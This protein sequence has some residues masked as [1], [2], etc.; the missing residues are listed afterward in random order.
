MN[1]PKIIFL[2]IGYGSTISLFFLDSWMLRIK[3]I[4]AVYFIALMKAGADH[5]VFYILFGL[6]PL[7]Y[8]I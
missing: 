1:I 4:I 3:V 2:L 5:S 6:K 8:K 7:A